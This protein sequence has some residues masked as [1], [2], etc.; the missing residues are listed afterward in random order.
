MSG[1]R[2]R[3]RKPNCGILPDLPDQTMTPGRMRIDTDGYKEAKKHAYE[4]QGTV[5]DFRRAYMIGGGDFGAAVH[6]TPDNYIYHIAKNDLWWDDFDS[7]PPCCY[8]GGIKELRERILAGDPTLKQD[9]YAAANNRNNHPC[10]TSAARLTLHLCSGGVFADIRERLELADGILTQTYSCGNQNGVIRGRDFRTVSCVSPADDVL[11]IICTPS[12]QAGHMGKVSLELTKDPMEVSANRGFLTKEQIRA[13]EEETEKYYTPAPF[14][15]GRD[16]GF[17]MRLRTGHDPENSPDFHYTVMM[18]S[19][20]E[21]IRAYAAG[22]KVIAEGRS[23]K[24]CVVFLL[25][26]VSTRDAADTAAEARR[27][28]DLVTGY[29]M[30]LAAGLTAE[31]YKHIWKRSWRRLP[32]TAKPPPG[33]LPRGISRPTPTGGTIS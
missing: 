14:V 15:D 5:T 13:L 6:G 24:D 2:L 3:R 1:N 27:R 23:Y 33:T 30:P 10:Q 21:N 26:V 8:T 18:R 31:W 16:F 28:L 19:S 22:S 7:D 9:L 32:D 4:R 29:H 25:T 20:D 11:A 17:T 12:A